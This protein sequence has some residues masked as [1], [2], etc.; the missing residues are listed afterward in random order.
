MFDRKFI[1][2]FFFL[3]IAAHTAFSQSQITV[4]QDGSGQYSDIQSAINAASPGD[5]IIILDNAVYSPEQQIHIS[6]NSRD[7]RLH[8]LTLRSADPNNK[9]TIRYQDR[10]N[11]GPRNYE[12]SRDPAH[13]T[14]YRNG[15][16]RISGVQGVTIDG[17]IVDGGGAYPFGYPG[18]WPE[19]GGEHGVY[20]LFYGNAALTLDITGNI[21]VRNS[22]FKNAYYG[23]AVKDRNAG[24]IFGNP[25]PGDIDVEDIIPFS[26]FGQ[27]GG[28]L[29]EN[30]RI[31]SNSWG[32]Y[33]EMMW[34]LGSTIRYNLIYDNYHTPSVLQEVMRVD[35]R[36]IT[37]GE[38]TNQNAYQYGGAI[39]FK[40]N[41]LSPL[42]IYN[43]TFFRNYLNYA[44]F[45]AA[46]VQHLIFNNIY[47][48]PRHYLNNGYGSQFRYEGWELWHPPFEFRFR[49]R[50]RHSVYAAMQEP[51]PAGGGIPNIMQNMGRPQ[52]GQQGALI[53]SPE[54]TTGFP[55]SANIR[56]IETEFLSE[57]PNSP[58][59]LVPNWQNPLVSQHIA[60]GG[61]D[62]IGMLGGDGQIAD[63]GAI[64]RGGA[65]E[66]TRQNHTRRQPF[67]YRKP[68]G[69]SV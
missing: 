14:F 40:E 65:T 16:L 45:W 51:P 28:H 43:N 37:D 67:L 41:L 58:D 25:N 32:L 4:S 3:A 52:S 35:A 1:H 29:I 18:V 31:H 56:W 38:V 47:G 20:G 15:A 19:E 8:N 39:A 11:V 69:S 21:I 48:R 2:L 26:A 59:F 61:C 13:I 6:V 42:A 54:D 64:Q 46:G 7:E 33:F 24:G 23:I 10:V 30:N 12:E 62:L 34:D 50:M 53:L 17:I 55:A 68:F 66:H 22:E 5:E 44:G 27:G 57:D 49:K 60:G 36:N 9:P 63:I